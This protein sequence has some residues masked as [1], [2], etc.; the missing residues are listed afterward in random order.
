MQS[1]PYILQSIFGDFGKADTEAVD[2]C[3]NEPL[4]TKLAGLANLD[5]NLIGELGLCNFDN[6]LRILS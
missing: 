1:D 6:S 2:W 3:K 5:V 4:F